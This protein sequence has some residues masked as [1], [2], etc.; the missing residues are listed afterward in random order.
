MQSITTNRKNNLGSATLSWVMP[1]LLLTVF[2]A[3]LLAQNATFTGLVT[4]SSG[5][6]IPKANII[7]HNEDTGVNITTTTTKSGD[8]T[9][10]YLKPG[11]YSI[12]AEVS[13]FKKENRTNLELQVAQVATA[14]FA[15]RVGSVTDS[16]N[17]RDNDLL[18]RGKADRGEVTENALV[19]EMPLNGRNPVML[20]QQDSAVMYRSEERRVGKEC[21]SRWSPYH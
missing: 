21:R 20:A 7:V 8:Y 9:V 17:V 6:V 13:G 11:H 2:S 12:S 10:P 4:D 16:V 15:L 3:T 19:T 5:A 14:N 1:L 18:A